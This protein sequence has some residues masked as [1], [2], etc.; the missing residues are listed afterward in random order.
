[1]QPSLRRQASSGDA[2]SVLR[3]VLFNLASRQPGETDNELAQQRLNSL[4]RLT[5]SIHPGITLSI[6]FDDREDVNIRTAFYNSASQEHLHVLETAATGILQVIQIFA[7]LILFRPKLLLVDEPDA[8]LHPDKQERLIEAIEEAAAEYQTQII[9][10]TH[11]QHIARA[12]SPNTKI[13][14][15]DNGEDKK[16]NE[17]A[18]RKLLGWGGLDKKCVFFIEDEDDKPIRTLLRQWPNLYRQ[19][20]ICRCFGID[21]LP[22]NSLLEGLME[23]GGLVIKALIHRDRDFMTVEECESWKRLYSAPNTHTWCTSSVDAEAYFCQPE[24]I[25]NLYNVTIEQATEWIDTAANNV[26][27]A[28]DKFF[29]KRKVINSLLH[30]DGGS[31]ESL[32]LWNSASGQTRQTV[33]GKK[34]LAALKPIVK[35]AGKDDKLLDRFVIPSNFTLAPDLRTVL[36]QAIA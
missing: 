2:G 34:L 14:W 21:N 31:P 24:Y 15:L 32:A 19:I 4:N 16:T 13:V 6:S 23:E 8:H 3:N 30:R 12:A 17:D 1:V 18:I 22:R 28:K 10:T 35:T 26:T 33:L 27:G 25:S 29:E 11:S 9:L 5:Q 7:Y 20:T 36:E